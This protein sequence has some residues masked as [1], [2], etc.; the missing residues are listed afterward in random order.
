MIDGPPIGI[1]LQ[2]EARE[3][4][5]SGEEGVV[6]LLTVDDIGALKPFLRQ[7]SAQEVDCRLQPF[8]E[9]G[10]LLAVHVRRPPGGLQIV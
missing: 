4:F 7:Y 1:V 10:F 5:D 2:N 8:G 6:L 3:V 9:R